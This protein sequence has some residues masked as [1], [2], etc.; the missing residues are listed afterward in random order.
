MNEKGQINLVLLGAPGAGK[1]TLAER[2][3]EE[4]NLLH[5]STG[6]MLRE[7]VKSGSDIGKKVAGYM[8]SGALVPD[9]IVTGAV[10]DR[11]SK[12][13]AE[14]GVLLDG[15]P[16]TGAQAESLD[17][18]LEASGKKLDAVIY[19]KVDENIVVER[20]CGR[21]MCRAC[22][23]IYHITNMPSKIEGTCD[24]CDGEL[25][26]R[27]DDTQETVKNR[28]AV[29]AD[30]TKDLVDYYLGKE[31]LKEL[32]G[33]TTPQQVLEDAKSLFSEEGLV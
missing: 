7:A 31:I 10:V 27:D 19:L 24:D 30:S 12:P 3:K 33:G 11:I 23:K 25:Y 6:D 14:K 17:E 8:D 20:L 16:R 9:E 32:D 29:Y 5:V 15:Y 1:G 28:L 4:Y 18:A 13:D 22:G 21:R 26:Q 2:L